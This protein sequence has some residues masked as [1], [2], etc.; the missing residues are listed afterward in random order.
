MQASRTFIAT[1]SILLLVI[2][3]G[4]FIILMSIAQQQKPIIDSFGDPTKVILTNQW[5][6][7]AITA[8]AT[9]HFV[10]MRAT[11]TPQ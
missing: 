7:T 6:E 9:A 8:S 11:I 10:K 1:L 4:I 3:P 5:V 2:I